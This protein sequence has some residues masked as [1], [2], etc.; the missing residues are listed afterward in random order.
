MKVRNK[1][2]EKDGENYIM[3]SSELTSWILVLLEDENRSPS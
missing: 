2:L 1:E 3:R